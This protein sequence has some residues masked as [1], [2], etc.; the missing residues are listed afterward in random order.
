MMRVKHL[1]R[2]SVVT[3]GGVD[4]GRVVDVV[5]DTGAHTIVQYEVRGK[6]LTPWF[7]KTFLIAAKQVLEITEDRLVVEDGAVRE[8]EGSLE[9]TP[10]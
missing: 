3:A 1:L 4:L 10:A 5:V 6:A 8:A 9:A 2:L 7:G